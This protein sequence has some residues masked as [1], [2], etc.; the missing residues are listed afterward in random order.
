MLKKSVWKFYLFRMYIEY[1]LPS[2]PLS[3]LFLRRLGQDYQVSIFICI[4]ATTWLASP[5]LRN[6][7]T[8]PVA[9]HSSTQLDSCQIPRIKTFSP[10]TYAIHSEIN[11]LR[12]SDRRSCVPCER[13]R[14]KCCQQIRWRFRAHNYL[15]VTLSDEPVQY[16]TD[17]QRNPRRITKIPSVHHL[18]QPT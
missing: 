14:G 1:K 15:N 17:I 7:S 8:I 10:K 12:N 16:G 2:Y 18:I 3:L 13:E 5:E 6:P 9:R 4:R 11:N